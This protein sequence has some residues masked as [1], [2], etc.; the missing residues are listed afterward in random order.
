MASLLSADLKRLPNLFEF[1]LVLVAQ[2]DTEV[3]GDGG[4]RHSV[5]FS[6]FHRKAG[7]ATKQLMTDHESQRHPQLGG[8]V[9]KQQTRGHLPIS[10]FKSI[11]ES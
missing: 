5:V 1:I 3:A 8:A 6:S 10:M 2:A 11:Y 4:Q 9:R 7:I